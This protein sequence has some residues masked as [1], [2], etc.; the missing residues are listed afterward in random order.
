MTRALVFGGTGALGAAVVAELSDEGWQ[1]DV[2]GRTGG[3]GVTVDL[4]NT[5]WADSAPGPYDGIVWAQGANASGAALDAAVPGQLR[6]LYEANVV[7]IIETLQ[8]L[9]TAG[10]LAAPARAVVLSSVWQVTTRANKVAY[11]ASKAALAGLLPAMAADLGGRLAVNGVLPGVIDTPMTRANLTA[12]QLAH[13]EGE[14][15]G[16]ALASPQ[17]VARTVSWLLGPRSAGVNAQWIAVDNGW[18]AVRS[19]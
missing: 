6:S 18:S 13:V 7:F 3:E 5:G 15:I 10:A 16:G 8:A 14:S 4:S 2:A 17:N 12:Q 11:V 19:V 1:V 9:T